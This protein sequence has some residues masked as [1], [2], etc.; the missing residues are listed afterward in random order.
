MRGPM[1]FVL[2]ARRGQLRA[3]ARRPGLA[4]AINSSGDQPT[5]PLEAPALLAAAKL[6][7][8]LMCGI[9]AGNLANAHA[10]ENSVRRIVLLDE[11]R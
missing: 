5:A 10:I 8:E 11:N 9:L 3:G 1:S 4:A 2:P 6:L 7:A